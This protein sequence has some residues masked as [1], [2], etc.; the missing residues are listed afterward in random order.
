M[1]HFYDHSII[2]ANDKYRYDFAPTDFD[3]NF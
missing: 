2:D 3:L 1:R